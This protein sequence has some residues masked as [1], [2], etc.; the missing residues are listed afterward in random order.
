MNNL[1]RKIYAA[2]V[3]VAVV[4]GVIVTAVPV[5]TDAAGTSFTDVKPTLNHYDPIMNLAGR[6]IVK[7]YSNSTYRPNTQLTRGQASKILALALKLDT[8]NV[9]NPGFKDIDKS[10]SSYKYIAALENAGLISGFED[11]TFKPNTS[12]TRAHMAKAI[13]LGFKLEGKSTRNPFRDVSNSAWYVNHVKALVSN[14]VTKGKSSTTFDPNSS[15]TRTQMASFVVRTENIKV[16]SNPFE[17]ARAEIRKVVTQNGVIEVGGKEV[18]E[19]K[20]DSRTNTLT[21]TAYNLDEGIKG[22]TG[23]NVFSSKLR[24]LGVKKISIGNAKAVDLSRPTAKDTLKEDFLALLKPS[25]KPSAYSDVSAE[26]VQVTLYS[27]K[28]G[29][30]FRE[31]FNVNFHVFVPSTN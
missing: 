1:L 4:L 14:K 16:A 8:I 12:M 5:T 22:M 2:T 30:Q 6:G 27:N 15:I 28:D 24:A 19:S 13:D 25:T 21:M 7:D 17:K 9:R 29:I 11:N 10:N 18:A 23:I 31:T 26:D 3:S 20:F